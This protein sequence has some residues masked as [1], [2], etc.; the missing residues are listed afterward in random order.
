MGPIDCLCS[1]ESSPS[2]RAPW[3]SAE[4]LPGPLV[5]DNRDGGMHVLSAATQT[6]ARA[7]S[8]GDEESLLPRP[9][10]RPP[11]LAGGAA[12]SERGDALD[13]RR[14]G[15]RGSTYRY[16]IRP[17]D[18][19]N[20]FQFRRFPSW[21]RRGRGQKEWGTVGVCLNG[22]Q[23]ASPGCTVGRQELLPSSASMART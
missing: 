14:V 10:G 4:I 11:P 20:G 18:H 19:D 6:G 22:A 16:G 12:W 23:K 2:D 7:A 5:G 3:G 17:F 8:T 13:R 21:R 15:N 9:A 1:C